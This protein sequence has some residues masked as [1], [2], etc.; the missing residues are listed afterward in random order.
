MKFSCRPLGEIIRDRGLSYAR[1]ESICGVPKSS[2][3]RFAVG[4]MKRIDMASV[5][6]IAEAVK[7]DPSYLLGEPELI[8]ALE[9]L[10]YTVAV[11]PTGK[12]RVADD[13]NIEV[14]E[15]FEYDEFDRYA[16]VSD[17]QSVHSRL[18]AGKK[19]T[20]TLSK[21]DERKKIMDLLDTLSQAELIELMAKTAE[22]LKER[23]LG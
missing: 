21:E 12:V 18:P 1:L 22:K 16:Q 4:Q 20:P 14:Y 19:E 5:K 23:G 2:I 3:Q 9:S 11:L 8:V 13:L 15:D 17:F 7:V 6:A 10:G